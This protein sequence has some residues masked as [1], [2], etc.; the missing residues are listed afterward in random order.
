M[1]RSCINCGASFETGRGDRFFCTPKCVAQ[2]YRTHDN[3]PNIHSQKAHRWAHVCEQ[4]GN[5]FEVNDY[6]ERGGQREP[7]YCTRACKQKAYRERGKDTQDQAAR[8]QEKDQ[9]DF[10][11]EFKRQSD[12]RRKAANPPKTQREPKTR[13]DALRILGLA[14]PLSQT[15][16][17]KRWREMI[18]HWHPDR[19]RAPEAVFMSQAI[20]R[21]YDI[22]KI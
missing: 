8:R 12:E 16:L 13:G 21:A 6:A 19:N 22:L 20:N 15:E 9:R 7:K 1:K 11:D 14:E 10:A 5:G 2:Y 4:C 17:K 18:G 3:P